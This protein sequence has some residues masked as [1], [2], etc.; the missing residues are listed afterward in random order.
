M[1]DPLSFTRPLAGGVQGHEKAP[2]AHKLPST[3]D[4]LR[5]ILRCLDELAAFE[6]DGGE[7]QS[8]K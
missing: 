8:L 4:P 7:L 6:R 5:K 1:C 3:A 2:L